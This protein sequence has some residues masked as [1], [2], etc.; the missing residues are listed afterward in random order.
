MYRSVSAMRCVLARRRDM[1]D[2]RTKVGQNG[3]KPE[4]GVL[5][6][7]PGVT[8]ACLREFMASRNLASSAAVVAQQ[9]PTTT[10]RPGSA[11]EICLK[12]C[13]C[14]LTPDGMD[15]RLKRLEEEVS[16]PVP[17]CVLWVLL[18]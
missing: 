13:L 4:E 15:S 11:R 1:S 7:V 5:Q 2:N 8:R 10:T 16:L 14:L 12:T 17:G 3:K 6:Y 18:G 9:S